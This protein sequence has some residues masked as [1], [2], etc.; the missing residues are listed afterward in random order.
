MQIIDADDDFSGMDGRIALDGAGVRRGCAAPPARVRPVR[1]ARRAHSPCCSTCLGNPRRLQVSDPTKTVST[2]PKPEP[3]KYP[4][5]DVKML[6]GLAA[7]RCAFPNCR[8]EV[9][10]DFD[11]ADG[12][13]QIGKIAHIIGHSDDGPR[14]DRNYPREKLDTYENWLLLCPTC[15]DTVDA[16]ESKYTIESLRKLKADHERWVRERLSVAISDVGFAELDI[17]TKAVM[18]ASVAQPGDYKLTPLKEKIK[19][20]GLTEASDSLI[21]LGLSQIDEVSDFVEQMAQL[22]SDFPGRLKDGFVSEYDR[23][24][25]TGM[26]GDALFEQLREFASNR[27]QDFRRQAAGLAVLTYLFERCDVFEK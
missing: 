18:R 7:A 4:L 27:S 15:H 21:T 16:L 2:M 5:P 25:G 9:V 26:A 3:R 12:R 8:H 1:W 6:Y 24:Q 22:D 19:K 14:G 23:L 13:K 20:N 10:L 11:P 17:A